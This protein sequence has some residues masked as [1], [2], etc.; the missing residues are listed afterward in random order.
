MADVIAEGDD[1]GPAPAR[2][3]VA[4]VRALGRDLAIAV[5]VDTAHQDLHVAGRRD[6][7]EAIR[8]PDPVPVADLVQ[9]SAALRRTLRIQELRSLTK[10]YC[11]RRSRCYPLLLVL[12]YPLPIVI[13][14]MAK[15][16]PLLHLAV[17]NR[18]VIPTCKIM[19]VI[20][21]IMQTTY[22]RNRRPIPIRFRP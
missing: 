1:R 18:A 10:P 6:P 12:S 20:L 21:I 4:A 2:G 13:N 17:M 8:V 22:N 15:A 14:L 19:S 11:P 7:Q 16:L 3:T 5:V 9:A